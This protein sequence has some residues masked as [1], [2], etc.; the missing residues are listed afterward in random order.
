MTPSSLCAVPRILNAVPGTLLWLQMIV[1]QSLWCPTFWL[2]RKIWQQTA[3]QLVR[4]HAPIPARKLRPEH[5]VH[6]DETAPK[7][8]WNIITRTHLLENNQRVYPGS[9]QRT[10]QRT[11]PDFFTARWVTYFF[12][13][14]HSNSRWTCLKQIPDYPLQ[15][16]LLSAGEPTSNKIFL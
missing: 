11:I 5:P 12:A 4:A 8:G 2:H 10:I 3:P 9:C 7:M 16:R 1:A 6:A 15:H 14:P 13:E